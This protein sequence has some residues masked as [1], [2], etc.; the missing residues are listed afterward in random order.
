[1]PIWEATEKEYILPKTV[2]IQIITAI[3]LKER[4]INRCSTV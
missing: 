2:N 4:V 1:M 3:L